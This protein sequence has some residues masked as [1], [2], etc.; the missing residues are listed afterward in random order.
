MTDLWKQAVRDF[1][2]QQIKACEDLDRA[3][4]EGGGETRRPLFVAPV[5]TGKTRINLGVALAAIERGARGVLKVSRSGHIA[6]QGLETLSRIAPHIS[7]GLYTGLKKQADR[8]IL[9]ATAQTLARH[10]DVVEAAGVVIIDEADQAYLRDESKEYAAIL[11]AAPRYAGVTGTPFVLEKGRTVPIFGPGKAFD[12]PCGL[13]TKK[14]ARD[15]GHFHFIEP[16]PITPSHQLKI[17]C[18]TKINISGDFDTRVQSCSPPM[19]STIAE[20][21]KAAVAL[22]GPGQQFLFFGSTT[23]QCDA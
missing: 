7:G 6:R 21:T 20:D 12:E 16:A 13:I 18:K 23:K 17:D 10:L 11:G 19:L 22:L 8:Q 4:F 14:A 15:A 9:F 2:P 5:S 3:I 1:R